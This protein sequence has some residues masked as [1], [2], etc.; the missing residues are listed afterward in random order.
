MPTPNK[1]ESKEEF[2]KRYMGSAEAI[3]DFPKQSQRFAVANSTWENHISKKT[4][5]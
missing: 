1:N 5:L 4:K 2:I 3:K